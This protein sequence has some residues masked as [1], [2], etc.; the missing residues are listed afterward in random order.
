MNPILD[1]DFRLIV[2]CIAIFLLISPTT[3]LLASSVTVS[4]LAEKL[5]TSNYEIKTR[6][7]PKKISFL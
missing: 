4:S 5:E 6:K 3:G 2:H 7:H 1:A